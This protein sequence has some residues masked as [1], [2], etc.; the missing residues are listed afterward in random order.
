MG[1]SWQLSKR[2]AFQPR[3]CG[4]DGQGASDDTLH[5]PGPH[6]PDLFGPSR[7]LSKPLCSRSAYLASVPQ[8]PQQS[9]SPDSNEVSSHSSIRTRQWPPWQQPLSSAGGTRQSQ[10]SREESRAPAGQRGFVEQWHP[11]AGPCASKLAPVS[12]CL[13]MGATHESP[14]VLLG[15]PSAPRG[16]VAVRWLS[17]QPRGEREEG[18]SA[19]PHQN[20][21][22][23]SQTGGGQAHASSS[24]GSP[25]SPI[26]PTS[27]SDVTSSATWIDRYLPAA[28]RPF[29]HLARLDKPTGTWLLA[30]PCFW[31]V[32]AEGGLQTQGALSQEEG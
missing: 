30:W 29:A 7:C 31:C 8:R 18:A 2:E 32:Q 21:S 14:V 16:S 12:R 20:E 5:A 22:H 4:R 11:E 24:A 26:S 15:L 25:I 19:L 6:R 3:H 9:Q 10:R 27:P 13:V 23:E 17:S 1:V 28:S